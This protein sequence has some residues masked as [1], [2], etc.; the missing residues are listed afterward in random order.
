MSRRLKSLKAT[1]ADAECPLFG[2]LRSAVSGTGGRGLRTGRK[3][4]SSG[5]HPL[6]PA[7]AA[8]KKWKINSD[9]RRPAA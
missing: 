6:M 7:G 1:L 4:G 5:R 2:N 9:S 3:S 8:R